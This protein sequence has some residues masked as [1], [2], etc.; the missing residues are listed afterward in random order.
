MTTT[1]P[2]FLTEPYGAYYHR[3]VPEEDAEL[4][5]TGPGTPCGE[6]LRR[7]WQPVAHSEELL[8]LPLRIQ[9]MG[10]DLVAFRDKGGKVGVLELHCPHRGTS[11]EFGVVEERGI[12]CCYHG[13]QFDVDGTILDTPGE[14]ANSTL[15]DRLRQGS[16]PVHEYRR[17]VFAY[18][19]PPDKRPPFP[20]YDVFD[21]PGF[22]LEVGTKNVKHCNWLQIMDNVVDPVHE[23]FLHARVSNVQFTDVEGRPMEGL[24]DVGEFD[25]METPVGLNCFQ[26][27][28]VGEDIWS[29]AIEWVIPNIAQIPDP[30]ALPPEYVNGQ[31]MLCALPRI[32]RWRVPKNDTE[33]LEFTFVRVPEGEEDE[34]TK[35]PGF[36]VA[37]QL[38]GRA[39]SYEDRQRYP[40]DYDAQVGQRMI[41]R[42]A[43]EHLATTDR[44]V[45]QM[46][47]MMREG[48]RAVAWGEDPKGLNTK[49]EGRVST[50]G[51]DTILRV[52]P[53]GS[54]EDDRELVRETG[55]RLAAG[56]LERPPSRVA[57]SW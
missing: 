17:L 7:F 48:I 24:K 11:L 9:I 23:S 4:T 32:F 3:E 6:Y 10:E 41:A 39:R 30:R 2:A 49:G 22:R 44:G 38:A 1:R 27:R 50:Y 18:M 31:E 55:L 51:S 42:H 29:R 52:A 36:A 15:K 53:A 46:R 28:R 5:H 19:G 57:G 16:Y 35:N 45:I 21:R 47:K 13:W 25:V 14:P 12:R 26:T 37:A 34:Y 40:A 54:E 8:D 33:T 20:V 43:L 56:F